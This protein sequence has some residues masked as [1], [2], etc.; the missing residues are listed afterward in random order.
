[1]NGKGHLRS[2]ARGEAATLPGDIDLHISEDL[3]LGQAA[4]YSPNG[5][6]RRSHSARNGSTIRG[7]GNVIANMSVEP[8][9]IGLDQ[10]RIRREEILRYAASHGARNVRVFGSAARGDAD[11]TSDVDLLVEMEPGRSL[12]DLV[13]LWQDLEDLL[14]THVDVLSDGG[15]SP[16]LRERIYAEAVPL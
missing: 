16:H 5:E 2:I 12:L 15:V 10:L 4:A 1:L 3:Q 13:G 8:A 9:Q 7:G 6:L 14:G 11:T